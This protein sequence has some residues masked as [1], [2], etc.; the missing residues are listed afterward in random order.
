[1]RPSKRCAAL[2][3]ALGSTFLFCSMPLEARAGSIN[4][5]TAG[6]SVSMNIDGYKDTVTTISMQYFT[7]CYFITNGITAGGFG[8]YNFVF[9]G[10]GVASGI[11]NISAS[12]FTIAQYAPWVVNNNS[13]TNNITGPD[14]ANYNRDLTN[15][16]AGGANIV[17]SYTPGAGDPTKVNFLQAFIQ[18]TNNAGF[19]TGTIDNGTAAG[20]YYNETGV[21]GTG[22]T[23]RT[24]T[25]PLT[26]SNTTP[27]W[28][29]D[30]PYR[31]N[32][33]VT[34]QVQYFQTFI[35]S[36]VTIGGTT[37]AVLYG[38]VQWGY[39][40]NS[41]K[42]PEPSSFALGLVGFAGVLVIARGRRLKSR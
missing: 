19:T 24:G 42:L 8:G 17:I 3:V 12:D 26:A 37:Y 7:S 30:I 27:A 31:T 34:S 11:A 41:T 13:T 39:T 6:S 28:L 38:G 2:V 4:G 14:S 33:T 20:P 29:V 16:N 1:M 21:A 5:T 32:P 15:Q 22:T 23:N 40:F 35:E 9:A 10:Q 18:N 36:N 25:I